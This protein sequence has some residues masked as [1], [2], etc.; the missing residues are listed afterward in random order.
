MIKETVSKNRK[1]SSKKLSSNVPVSR[2]FSLQQCKNLA[3]ATM[4]EIGN[5]CETEF[6]SVTSLAIWIIIGKLRSKIEELQ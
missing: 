4:D 6:D 5:I 3:H 2:S 1:S